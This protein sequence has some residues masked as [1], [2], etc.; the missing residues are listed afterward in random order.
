ML[1][2]TQLLRVPHVDHLFDISPDG[3][4]LAFA[5][6]KTGD[7]QIYEMDLH[8][9]PRFDYAI[10]LPFG[11]DVSA[12][13]SGGGAKFNPRYSPDGSHL[14]YVLDVDGS[15]SYHLVIYDPSKNTHTD[16]T[17]NISHALQPNFCWSPDGSQLAF[18]SD[19][20][21]HFSTYIVSSNGGEPQLVLD[22]G[23]PAWQV[24]WSPDG[25]HLAVSCEMHGQDYGIFIVESW[26]R[27]SHHVMSP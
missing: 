23:H 8:P 7:W 20:K 22:T 11:H 21:G 4:R 10:V 18:L 24:E 2:L 6:N 14:A 16:L 9:S 17:P 15:E 27:R 5:W 3:S 19:E 26:K 25:R 13:T 12:I 1:D